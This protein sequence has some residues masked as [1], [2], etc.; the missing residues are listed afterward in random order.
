MAPDG[1]PERS[2]AGYR[3]PGVIPL[4]D[5]IPAGRPPFVTWGLIAA[6]VL[7][8]AWQ[9]SLGIERSVLTGGAIPFEL[10][11]LQDVWPRDL[12]PPP[13]TVFTSMFLHGGLAHLGGN[14]LFL[15][16]FGNNVEDALGR[17]RFLLFYLAGGIA[18]AATQ[19]LA[20]SVQASQLA[21]ADASALMSTP[22][23]GASGAIAAVLGAYLLLFP[24]A[25]IQ[26]FVVL[27]V[28][29]QLVYLP[30][31]IFIGIWFLGQLLAVAM[32]ASTGVAFFAHIGGFLAGLGLLKLLGR[33]P[34]WSRAPPRWATVPA[35]PYRSI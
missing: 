28:I 32:G 12:V 4:R 9:V 35:G 27:I 15:W 34:G 3:W 21:G 30:A 2:G 17:L 24:R 13:F 23:V 5:D 26:T 25:R 33:R 7:A 29:F 19:T 6:N 31:W 16:I 20:V 11:T 1:A 14:M 10:L 8:F 22:M 18:A